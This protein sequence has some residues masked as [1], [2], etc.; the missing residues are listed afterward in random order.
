MKRLIGI[1][2]TIAVLAVIVFAVLHRGRYVSLLDDAERTESHSVDA[3]V[4][5]LSSP[6]TVRDSLRAEAPDTLS[7]AAPEAE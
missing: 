3:A 4:S 1:V 2:C 6:G 5:G 7:S